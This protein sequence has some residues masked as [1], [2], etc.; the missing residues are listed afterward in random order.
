MYIFLDVRR[1]VS[2]SSRKRPVYY[3]KKLLHGVLFVAVFL[4]MYDSSAQRSSNTRR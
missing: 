1:I 3:F 4:R 2:H